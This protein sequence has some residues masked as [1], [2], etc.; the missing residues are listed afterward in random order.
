MLNQVFDDNATIKV[1][2]MPSNLVEVPRVNE[3]YEI[4]SFY[5]GKTPQYLQNLR[6]LDLVKNSNQ[7]GDPLMN[8]N[9]T[10]FSGS[11]Q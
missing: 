8:L 9:P 2:K 6:T 7:E 10:F 4:S 1:S 5:N 3:K 11:G